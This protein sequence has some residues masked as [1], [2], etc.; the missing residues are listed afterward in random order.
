MRENSETICCGMARERVKYSDGSVNYNG[1]FKDNLSDGVWTAT[2]VME[3][4]TQGNGKT[5]KDTAL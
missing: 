2:I 3:T 5:T 4:S 1:E